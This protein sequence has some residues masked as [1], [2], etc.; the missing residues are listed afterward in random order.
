M[1][2]HVS[3][4]VTTTDPARATLTNGRY[5]FARVRLFREVLTLSFHWHYLETVECARES[6]VSLSTARALLR[7]SHRVKGK[8]SH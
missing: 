3:C 5:P 4:P 1:S 2:P 6:F 7:K 8:V